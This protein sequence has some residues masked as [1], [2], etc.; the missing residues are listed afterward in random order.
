MLKQRI[1][2]AVILAI[3]VITAIMIEDS[4]WA[5][6]LVSTGIFFATRELLKLTLKLSETLVL[7]LAFGFA[8]LFWFFSLTSCR[9]GL[10]CRELNYSPPAPSIL[11]LVLLISYR[12]PSGEFFPIVS[13]FAL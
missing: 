8:L 5:S 13:I 9:C 11:F 7:I 1:I 2:T 12:L 10:K 3:I 6:L 4:R